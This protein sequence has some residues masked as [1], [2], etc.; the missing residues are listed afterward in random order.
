MPDKPSQPTRTALARALTAHGIHG[1]VRAGDLVELPRNGL[2]HRHWRVGRTGALLRVPLS[3]AAQLDRQ[4][5][6]FRRMAAS[7]HVPALYATLPPQPGVKFGALVVEE[8]KGRAPRVPDDFKAIA[9]A[10]AA[11]HALPVPPQAA[12]AAA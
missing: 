2:M 8:I 1:V 11:I 6:T 4:A 12:P 3:A 7:R 10:L 9:A 5:E